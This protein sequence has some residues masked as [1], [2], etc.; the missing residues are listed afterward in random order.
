MPPGRTT[1][2]FS[3]TAKAASGMNCQHQHREGPVEGVIL[4][5]QGTGIRLPEAD[6]RVGIADTREIYIGF[7]QINS[8]DARNVG[9][10]RQGKCQAASPAADIEHAV[11]VRKATELYQEGRESAAP[12]SHDLFVGVRILVVRDSGGIGIGHR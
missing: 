3:A 8:G 1:R 7:G 5:R 11:A 9:N 4:E 12:P 6:P 2:R 10:F